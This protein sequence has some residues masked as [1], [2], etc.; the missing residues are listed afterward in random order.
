MIIDV[1]EHLIFQ[2]FKTV[3]KQYLKILLPFQRSLLPL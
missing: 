2:W 1:Q 3:A